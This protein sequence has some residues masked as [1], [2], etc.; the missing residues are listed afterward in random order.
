MEGFRNAV[1]DQLADDGEVEDTRM[2][3]E[4]GQ[5]TTERGLDEEQKDDNQEELGR[6]ELSGLSR[7]FSVRGML[8]DS[9]YHSL[10]LW[11]Q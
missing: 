8:W 7:S 10:L 3:R 1:W 5:Q 4:V 9:P 6:L 11:T 2:D